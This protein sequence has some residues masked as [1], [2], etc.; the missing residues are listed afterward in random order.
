MDHLNPGM[1]TAAIVPALNEESAIGK[2]VM[3]ASG[4]VDKIIVVDNGSTDATAIRA[5]EAGAVVVREE[6]RGYGYACLRG[7]R[8]TEGFDVLVF[9]DGDYSDFPEEVNSLL[10]PI[11]EG[12]SDLVIGSRLRG[13]RE[14]G[15]MAFHA[16]AANVVLSLIVTVLSGRK[17]TDIGPFRAIRRSILTQLNMKERTYGWTLEMM[18]KASRRGFRIIEV[19]VNYRRRLGKSK[20]SGSII[21]SI[22][23]FSL[24]IYTLRYFF[25]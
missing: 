11:F 4:F 19:P 9:L 22:K 2:V 8:E 3:A 1:K 12:K 13:R 21:A 5:R 15:A 20:V 24:M 14:K 6:R 10:Y 23:A 25:F 7:I 16:I 18:V 17:V